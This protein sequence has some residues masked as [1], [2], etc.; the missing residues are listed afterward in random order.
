MPMLD[1]FVQAV[2]R[3]ALAG[4]SFA[5]AEEQRLQRSQSVFPGSSA[6]PAMR[7]GVTSFVLLLTTSRCHVV[8]TCRPITAVRKASIS[9]P[10]LA[11]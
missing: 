1:A 2:E 7:A 6:A 11:N 4:G 8:Q 9:V 10:T 3:F 5:Q